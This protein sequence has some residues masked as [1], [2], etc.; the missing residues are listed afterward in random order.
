[1]NNSSEKKPCSQC[2]KPKAT[3]TCGLCSDPICKS[4]AEFISEETFL[5]LNPKPKE[6]QHSSYC[7]T[8][9]SQQIVPLQEKYEET[10]RRAKDILVFDITQGKETRLIKRLEKPIVVEDC[11]DYDETV[12]RL[13]FIAADMG[14]N[15][16]VDTDIKSKK[17]RS[18]SYQTSR[19]T[20][21]AVPAQVSG[22]R[23]VKDRSIWQNPN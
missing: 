21:V 4:C 3:L 5:F 19:F 10:L 20:G 17:I 1:M 22:D 23:L 14:Y 13:A 11:A 12:L 18:G 8:C 15:A 6:L 9:F 2:Q 7:S 16:I